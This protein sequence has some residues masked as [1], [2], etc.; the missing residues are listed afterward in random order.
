MMK[1]MKER[2]EKINRSDLSGN[3]YWFPVP[4]KN[5]HTDSSTKTSST[6]A[7]ADS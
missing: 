3:Q 2:S 1:M 7:V 6:V 5:L 4:R